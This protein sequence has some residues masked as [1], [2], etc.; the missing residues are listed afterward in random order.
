MRGVMLVAAI[1]LANAIAAQAD[2]CGYSSAGW[3][4]IA[5]CKQLQAGK[6]LMTDIYIVGLD[7][8]RHREPIT[9]TGLRYMWIELEKIPTNAHCRV[10]VWKKLVLCR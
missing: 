2:T 3:R 6:A 5:D 1:L 8:F 9:P 10:H 7:T 4:Q